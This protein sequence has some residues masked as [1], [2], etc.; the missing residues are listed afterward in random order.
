MAGQSAQRTPQGAFLGESFMQP[1]APAPTLSDGDTPDEQAELVAWASAVQRTRSLA[2][3]TTAPPPAPPR[4]GSSTGGSNTTPRWDPLAATAGP[5]AAPPSQEPGAAAEPPQAESGGP[6]AG[7]SEELVSQLRALRGDPSLAESRAAAERVAAALQSR[8]AAVDLFSARALTLDGQLAAL[9]PAQQESAQLASQLTAAR[10]ELSRLRERAVALTGQAG[11]TREALVVLERTRQVAEQVPPASRDAAGMHS[12]RRKGYETQ[13]A[14]LETA[15]AARD[16]QLL[17]ENAAYRRLLALT[18][19]VAA[20]NQTLSEEAQRL[21]AVLPELEGSCEQLEA[22]A[23]EGEERLADAERL[24]T[25]AEQAPALLAELGDLRA[26]A[27]AFPELEADNVLLQQACQKLGADIPELRRQ[28]VELQRRLDAVP[29]LRQEISELEAE[30]RQVDALQDEVTQLEGETAELLRLQQE[31]GALRAEVAQI[32]LAE[33]ELRAAQQEAHEAAEQSAAREA[34][35][36]GLDAAEQEVARREEDAQRHAHMRATALASIRGKLDA[37]ERREAERD[38][39][40]ALELEEARRPAREELEAIRRQL[41]ECDAELEQ[42]RELEELE[43]RRLHDTLSRDNSVVRAQIAALEQAAEQRR[44]EADAL[45]GPLPAEGADRTELETLSALLDTERR[46]AEDA[47]R[48]RERTA[49]TQDEEGAALR[50]RLQDA[51]GRVLRL[52][53]KQAARSQRCAAL[54]TQLAA[55]RS[56]SRSSGDEAVDTA[57][58]LKEELARLRAHVRGDIEDPPPLPPPRR[59]PGS[60]QRTAP[61]PDPGGGRRSPTP[62]ALSV[63]SPGCS[64]SPSVGS[65]R[66]RFSSAGARAP[67]PFGAAARRR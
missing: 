54:R 34:L 13:A 12:V 62:S 64:P 8:R 35:C 63:S 53:Q 29:S 7:P 21:G 43:R 49:A 26:E 56:I 18:Q 20:H 19:Q 60:A 67:P 57:V 59:R 23:R 41:A 22:R 33:E 2:T 47:A 42:R 61:W 44:R 36:R 32:P 14:A 5:P 55:V 31:C 38:A 37:V 10:E 9:R 28:A 40:H 30:Q 66:R 16:A 58:R 1:G 15:N 27:A 51:E 24:R 65:P 25:L 46:L 52:R 17:Q 39:Q 45:A 4:T 50:A 11:Q 48:E 3:A 6:R